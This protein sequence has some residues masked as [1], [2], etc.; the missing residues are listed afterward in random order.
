MI[1]GLG[2][3]PLIELYVVAAEV[4]AVLAK[5]EVRIGA[6]LVGN[7]V[8]SL[9]MAGVSITVCHADEEMLDLWAAP[10]VAPGLRWGN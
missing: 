7:Y 4:A 5:H 8:T 1:N 2:G 9:D 6:S 3:T 10:V